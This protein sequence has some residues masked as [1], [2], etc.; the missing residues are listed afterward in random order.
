MH[1]LRYTIELKQLACSCCPATGNYFGFWLVYWIVFVLWDW[2]E[3]VLSRFWFYYTR[4]SNSHGLVVRVTISGLTS[5][6]HDLTSRSLCFPRWITTS[7]SS[8]LKSTWFKIN[9]SKLLW[10]QINVQ[11]NVCVSSHWGIWTALFLNLILMSNHRL[12]FMCSRWWNET[13]KTSLSVSSQC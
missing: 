8:G 9:Y 13:S 1:Q 4:P 6:F 12:R 5:W 10:I 11:C 7:I 3:W 2:L